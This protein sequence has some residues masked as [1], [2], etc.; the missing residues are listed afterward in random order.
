MGRKQSASVVGLLPNLNSASARVSVERSRRAW[1]PKIPILLF[2]AFVVSCDSLPQSSNSSAP[3]PDQTGAV[4]KELKTAEK[5]DPKEDKPVPSRE[6][7]PSEV[8]R[9]LSGSS[10]TPLGGQPTQTRVE[11]FHSG[12]EWVAYIEGIV[13]L[14]YDGIWTVENNGDR[15]PRLCTTIRLRNGQEVE[16]Y[17][18]ICRRIIEIDKKNK[19]IIEAIGQ[20]NVY[21]EALIKTLDSD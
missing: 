1:R 14:R 18:R 2:G 5:R 13:A 17:D 6:V 16:G 21:V 11:E 3:V 10:L 9:Q 12:G 7:S 19:V 15:L 20:K 4:G 8:T